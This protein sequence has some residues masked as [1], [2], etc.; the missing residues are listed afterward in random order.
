ADR[1]AEERIRAGRRHRR[2]GRA[3]PGGGR[4]TAERHRRLRRAGARPDDARRDLRPGGQPLG[5]GTA[6]AAH[7]V[8][9]PAPPGLR[10][11]GAAPADRGRAARPL[12]PGH[13]LRHRE[14]Q[15]EV[16]RLR[17]G[18]GVAPGLGLLPAHQRRLGRRR[19]DDGRHG[20]G[21][22]PAA[23]HPRL[24]PRPGVR[25]PRGGPVLRRDGPFAAGCGLRFGRA[26]DRQSRLHHRP[27]RPRRPRLGAQHLR[28]GAAPAAVPVPRRRRL[29]AARLPGRAGEVRRA[30]GGRHVEHRAAAGG[31][32]CAA[33]PAAGGRARIDLR[34][35]EGPEEQVLRRAREG[36]GV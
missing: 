9:P 12:G 14:A 10:A 32:A 17:G 3:E 22:R 16:G 31:R 24:A 6:R 20:G 35:P 15:H 11:A 4:R 30:D 21:E 23:G 26:A 29:A 7:Q 19:R 27:P 2:P 36:G 34:E 25:P 33:A 1:S 5:G 13:P 28:E 8:A 18:G